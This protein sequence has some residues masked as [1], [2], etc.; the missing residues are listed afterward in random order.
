MPSF[1][2][3]RNAPIYTQNAGVLHLDGPSPSQFED[4]SN[5]GIKVNGHGPP[6]T[7]VN[8]HT[9]NDSFDGSSSQSS[10]HTADTSD[11]AQELIGSNTRTST[12]STSILQNGVCDGEGEQV[13]PN[14]LDHQYASQKHHHHHQPQPSSPPPPPPNGAPVTT[15]LSDR[16]ASPL[17][18]LP[19]GI[20]ERNSS[21][22]SYVEPPSIRTSLASVT[23]GQPSP[24]GMTIQQQTQQGDSYSGGNNPAPAFRAVSPATQRFGLDPNAPPSQRFSSPAQMSGST[25]FSASTSNLH[26]TSAGLKHRHTLEVPRPGQPR[27]SR[28]GADSALASGRFSPTG[29]GPTGGARR[30]S[31][32]LVR[33]NTRSMHSDFPRDEAY[34]D[35]DAMRWAE[36]YRQKRASKRKKKEEEDDDRVLIGNK[37]DEKH[38]NWVTAY[39][40]LTGI[41][42][43]VSRTNAKLD[44]PLTDA[45]FEA[46]QKS[47]FDM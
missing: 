20:A 3:D 10:T 44:R 40:M 35:E 31:L 39:N 47:T 22:M 28:D 11:A 18:P 38:A 33:R 14:G 43:A 37:V 5:I 1:L 27:G 34:P 45:D 46:K 41:R 36:A 12:M 24:I 7:I 8:S 21:S 19:N 30:A 6:R 29:S 9:S 17:P 16:S 2:N 26:P 15:R 13:T 4:P 23:S 32:S 25:G 42:V